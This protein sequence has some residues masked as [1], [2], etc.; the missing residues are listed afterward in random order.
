MKNTVIINNINNQLSRLH[1][2]QQL[3]VLMFARSLSGQA[4]CGVSG[5]KLLH[6]AS[7]INTDE[8]ETMQKAIDAGC[9]RINHDEW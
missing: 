3:R 9:E 6:F 1:K 2:E 5:K 7:A 8:L 4:I